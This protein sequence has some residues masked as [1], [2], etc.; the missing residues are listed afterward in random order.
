MGRQKKDGHFFNCYLQK[1]LLERLTAYSAETGIPKTFIVEKALQ[2]YLD[3]V[4][5][6]EKISDLASKE[7]G[8]NKYNTKNQCLYINGILR[9]RCTSYYNEKRGLSALFLALQNGVDM[10]QIT[11]LCKRIDSWTQ[12]V[13]LMDSYGIQ[14]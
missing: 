1:E 7:L 8:E 9:N 5:E 11:H 3:S 6:I 14:V 12:F 2:K 10:E 4:A 13:N